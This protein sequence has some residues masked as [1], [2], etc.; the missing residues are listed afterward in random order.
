MQ[1]RK[2]FIIIQNKSIFL[3]IANNYTYFEMENSTKEVSIGIKFDR[4]GEIDNMNERYYADVTI[5]ASWEEN[6]V[7]NKY[8]ETVD[9]NPSLYIENIMVENKSTI[10]FFTEKNPDNNTTK[11]TQILTIK[12]TEF[13]IFFK[14]QL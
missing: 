11:I 9:W 1:L 6:R 12:G 7:I 13:L 14:I 3:F 8:N 2:L 10:K 5:E 4:I